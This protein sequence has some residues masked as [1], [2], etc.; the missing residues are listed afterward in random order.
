MVPAAEITTGRQS[1]TEKGDTSNAL[2]TFVR[3][4]IRDQARVKEL[5]R[6]YA[7]GDNLGDGHVKQEIAEAINTLLEPM[8]ARR[9]E[10]ETPQGDDKVAEI[11]R[12]G[13][14]RANAVAEETLYMAKR[15]MRLDF[16]P[17]RLTTG[18]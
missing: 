17:R 11:I 8:R 18:P 15:A 6:R 5:E 14:A 1:P 7:E 2:F 4:F 10:F 3:A 16:G 9:A 12:A 13:T